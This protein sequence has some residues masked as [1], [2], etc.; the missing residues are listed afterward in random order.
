MIGPSGWEKY[1]AKLAARFYDPTEGTVKIGGQDL[2]EI[3]PE[4][5]LTHV[6]MVFQ[7]VILFDNTVYENIKLGRK[8][9]TEE[10][11]M[12]AARLAHC[13]EFVR[14]LPTAIRP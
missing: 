4:A 5:I 3:D 12:E 13:D 10:E 11:V 1:A 9:A 7:D 6:S 8:N 14:R 2:K